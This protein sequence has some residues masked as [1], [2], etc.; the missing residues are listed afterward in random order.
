[1]GE[2]VK[3][4]YDDDGTPVQLTAEYSRAAHSAHNMVAE[5]GQQIKLGIGKLCLGLAE[6]RRG[7][8]YLALGATCYREYAEDIV[9]IDERTAH[10][11]AA[12]G[13]QWPEEIIAQ[14]G[15]SK[16]ERLLCLPL[17]D[18][19]DLVRS[20]IFES[21]DGR[22][23]TLADL[24]AATAKRVAEITSKHTREIREAQKLADTYRDEIGALKA[25]LKS[26]LD[27]GEDGRTAALRRQ[28]AELTDRHATEMAEM[29]SS[30]RR[31]ETR[32]QARKNI[33]RARALIEDG[34]AILRD[35]LDH[36]E[37]DEVIASEAH[38]VL[39]GL[40]NSLASIGVTV[41]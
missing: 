9:G 36:H 16:S 40:Y 21:A 25:E 7:R 28:I 26:A 41:G 13:D 3:T 6:I 10:R 19:E 18:R 11:Y 30:L 5:G 38:L 1:M 27:A 20:A 29:E 4:I 15:V 8:Y 2:I 22:S 33:A 23:Y 34:V 37:S 39:Q 32:E 31:G 35:T 14:L 24:E 12:L 17:G